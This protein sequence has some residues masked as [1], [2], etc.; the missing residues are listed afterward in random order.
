MDDGIFEIL[1]ES[2]QRQFLMAAGVQDD[3]PEE[4]ARLDEFGLDSE[5]TYEIISCAEVR[6]HDDQIERIVH[7]R[8]PWTKFLWNGDWSAKSPCWTEKA[9]KQVKLSKDANIDS[10]WMQFDEFA[11]YFSRI[12][13]CKYVEG[14]K[15]TSF[16]TLVSP[17]GYHLIK[18][19]IHSA[20]EQTI[21]VS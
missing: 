21:S 4:K 17:S 8:N 15:F 6:T 14:Y 1:L 7:I 3:D 9:K 20:G 2:T 13:I 10:F 16:K 12:S 11:Q 19:Q 18:L 5:F